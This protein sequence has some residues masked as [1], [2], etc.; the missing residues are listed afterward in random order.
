M[1]TRL[2]IFGASFL[3]IKALCGSY[4]KAGSQRSHTFFEGKQS[5]KNPIPQ[6]SL[7]G[8]NNEHLIEF[9]AFPIN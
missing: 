3:I 2:V 4:E 8:K 1:G 6:I 9:I 7:D 5:S